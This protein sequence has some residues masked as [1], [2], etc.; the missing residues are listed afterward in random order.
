MK[1]LGEQLGDCSGNKD[2]TIKRLKDM[3]KQPNSF[4]DEITET[5][6]K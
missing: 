2:I 5:E 3:T 6:T 4:S 1:H